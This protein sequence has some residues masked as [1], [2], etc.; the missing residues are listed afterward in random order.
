MQPLDPLRILDYRLRHESARL[1]VS[2]PL[3]LEEIAFRA[4]DWAAFEA[5][6]EA[7]LHGCLVRLGGGHVDDLL[8]SLGSR[9]SGFPGGAFAGRRKEFAH[10]LRTGRERLTAVEPRDLA[11]GSSSRC[12]AHI[13]GVGQVLNQH[14]N[15]SSGLGPAPDRDSTGGAAL[16]T[17]SIRG[18]YGR[19]LEANA[20]AGGAQM[21]PVRSSAWSAPLLLSSIAIAFG[22]QVG[23]PAA[24][25]QLAER[26]CQECHGAQNTSHEAPAFSAIAAMPSTTALSLDVF[27]RTSH[28]TMPNLMLSDTDRGDLIAYILSLR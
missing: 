7:R 6:E 24:G 4:D 27:L 14:R 12:G 9:Y 3:Q 28:P 18:R 16:I 21:M 1:K 8:Y 22:Q 15:M 23:D 20:L 10:A 13:F 2:A 19:W 17:P 26:T 25:K 5:I 11:R